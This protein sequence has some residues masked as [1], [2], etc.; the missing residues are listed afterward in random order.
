MGKRVT[1]VGGWY[2]QGVRALADGSRDDAKRQVFGQ[3]QRLDLRRYQ[4]S[5]DG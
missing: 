4:Q 3:G 1:E 5:A 2:V